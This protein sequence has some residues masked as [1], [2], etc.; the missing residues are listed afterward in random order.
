MRFSQELAPV[1]VFMKLKRRF[2]PSLQIGIWKDFTQRAALDHPTVKQEVKRVKLQF[3]VSGVVACRYII[4]PIWAANGVVLSVIA[5]LRFITQHKLF[6]LFNC[7]VQIPPKYPDVVSVLLLSP[8][9]PVCLACL[10]PAT[11]NHAHALHAFRRGAAWDFRELR[12]VFAA[13]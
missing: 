13:L 8:L 12:R 6:K 10:A 2:F 1:G 3:C 5:K 11:Y 7:H 4:F 9:L